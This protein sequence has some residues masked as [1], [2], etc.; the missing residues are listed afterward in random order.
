MFERLRLAWKYRADIKILLAIIQDRRGEHGRPD[1]IFS[2]MEG[3]GA[4][5]LSSTNGH[6]LE[7]SR[8]V[9]AQRDG[10][11]KDFVKAK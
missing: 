10:L 2:A 5:E 4:G 11:I 1:A 7:A 9:M 8:W 3:L 6:F